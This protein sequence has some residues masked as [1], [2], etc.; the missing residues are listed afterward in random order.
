MNAEPT[1]VNKHG[2]Q[3]N[4]KEMIREPTPELIEP[5]KPLLPKIDNVT[6]RHIP[7]QSEIDSILKIIKRKIIRDYQLP[8]LANEIRIAQETS[9]FFKPVYDYIAYDILPHDK[10]AAQAVKIRSEE[11]ILVDGVLFR[12]LFHV[13]D[14]NFTL[15]LAIPETMAETIISR[16]HDSLL[17]NHQGVIRTYKT[18]KRNFYIPR[19]FEKVNNYV[20]A[21]MKC[22]LFRGKTDNLRPYQERIPDTYIPFD[23]LSLDLKTMPRS[24]SGFKH[25]MVVCDEI[26]RYLIAVPLRTLDA[27]TISEAL[28]QKVVT[29]FGP[30]SCIITDAASSLIG[31]VLTSLCETLKIEQ[32]TISV[33]NHGSLLVERHIRTLSD[34][35]KVNLEPFGRDWPMYVPTSCY[36]YNV[37]SSPQLGNMSPYELVFAREPKNLANISF[38]P[39]A[40]LSHDYHD[41]ADH[42]KRK[43]QHISESMLQLQR[44]KQEQ[45]NVTISQ[46]LSSAPIYSLGQLVYLYKPTSSS[47]SPKDTCSKKI[48]SHWVGP[49]VIHQILDRTHYMLATLKGEILHDI[50]SFNRLKP[51]FMRSTSQNRHITYISQLKSAMNNMNPQTSDR[52]IEETIAFTDENGLELPTITTNQVLCV[53]RTDPVD[54]NCHLNH[55]EENKGLCVPHILDEEQIERQI[56]MVRKAPSNSQPITV[57]RARFKAAKLQILLSFKR[58]NCDVQFWFNVERY[59]ECQHLLD[60]VTDRKIPCSGSPR[61]F[62]SMLYA[63]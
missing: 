17:S 49:L 45:Q 35:L 55:M 34:F 15:Q 48:A 57:H 11:F 24:A 23:R 22:Q 62:I 1:L 43:F 28:I 21:C 51:C 41:Y 2:N 46:K 32:K 26:T 19:L 14:D 63:S 58:D 31:K 53:S 29:V 20:K 5:P 61:S 44:R 9:P 52:P 3:E 16:Y 30:P 18:I 56:S 33:Q 25:L 42:L 12:L 50:F 7:R 8:V 6:Y 36:S 40:T 13:H 47:L 54:L 37:F 38:E 39:L 10:R 4:V 27:E 60:L 59:P